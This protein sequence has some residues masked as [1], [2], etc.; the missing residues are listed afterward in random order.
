MDDNKDMKKTQKYLEMLTEFLNKTVEMSDQ[1]LIH[2]K[3]TDY[4]IMQKFKPYIGPQKNITRLLHFYDVYTEASS[5]VDAVK[6]EIG[7]AE[8]GGGDTVS[9]SALEELDVIGQVGRL[10][11]AQSSVRDYQGVRIVKELD[12]RAEE[13]IGRL[14]QMTKKAFFDSLEKLP[15]IPDNIRKYADFLLGVVEKKSFLG[16]YT[17]KVNSRL[18]FF[19]VE[20]NFDSILQQTDNLTSYLNFI[21][22]INR[23][24]LG[25]SVA[26][27]INFGL[28]T[29]MIVN[30]KRIVSDF[31]GHVD[32]VKVVNDTPASYL[33]SIYL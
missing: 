23:T 6:G 9:L 21:I 4:K 5:E 3:E 15:K 14:A 24:I 31:L 17:K 22:E 19:V 16:Q 30:L 2:L 10:R 20:N 33:Y 32:S 11:S 8:S 27:N 1:L 18:G 25:R 26:H 13:Q 28:I 29:L 12:D 7:R